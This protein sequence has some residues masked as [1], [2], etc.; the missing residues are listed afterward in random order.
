LPNRS[1]LD[2]GAHHDFSQIGERLRAGLRRPGRLRVFEVA[3]M[4]RSVAMMMMPATARHGVQIG[5]DK[6]GHDLPS[7]LPVGMIVDAPCSPQ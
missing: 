4:V 6:F 7:A 3:G 2:P 5:I 1:E